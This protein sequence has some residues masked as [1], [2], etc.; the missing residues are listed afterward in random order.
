MNIINSLFSKRLCVCL[1]LSFGVFGAVNIMAQK[2]SLST[3]HENERRTPYPQIGQTLYINP[4]PLLVPKNRK[5]ADCLQF[6]LSQQK[7]FSGEGNMLSKPVPWCMFNPHQKLSAGKWYWRFRSVSSS[8]E[9]FPWSETMEFVMTDDVPTFVTPTFDVLLKKLSGETSR[10]NCFLDDKLGEARQKMYTH[11][12]YNRMITSGR[13]GLAANYSTDTLVSNHATAMVDLCEKLHTAYVLTQRDV[14][15]NKMVQLIRWMLPSR[16][17]DRQLSND[18]YAGDLAYLLACSYET[19]Y[20]R[21]TPQER[22]QMEQL[23]LR[24]IG[25]YYKSHFAGSMEN[26]IFNN[27]LW[28]FTLRRLTQAS[29]VLYDK[30]PEAHEFLEYAYELW[31]ARAPAT[32]F[33]RDGIWINGTCYFSANAITLYY[34]PAL[35]S[36]LTG[37]DFFQ[38]PWY[39]GVGKAMVYNWPPHSISVGWGDGHEQMNDKPLII[40]SAFAEFLHRELGDPYAAWFTGIDQRYLM[41]DEMRLYRMVRPEAKEKIATLPANEPK[42]TW[43]RDCGE[44]IANSNMA[45]YQNNLCLSFRSSPF[46]SGSHTQSTQN[47]FNLYFRGVPVYGSTGYYMNFTD[48]HNLLD[49]RHTRGHNTLLVDGI[50]QPFSIKAYG[51]IVRMLGG[52]N[53]SYCLGDA[54]NAYCGLNDY[55]MWIRNFANQGV[56]ESRENGFGETSLTLYRRH[57]FL[58]HPD[59]VV[60]YDEMEAKS[61]VRWDWLLHSPVPFAIDKDTKLLTTRNEAKQFTSVAQLFSNQACDITQTD[62]FVVAPDITKAV[63]GEKLANQWHLT[64]SFASSKRNRILTIIQV[65]PDGIKAADISRQGN[66]LQCGD[67]VIEAELNAK[68]PAKLFIENRVNKA[69][70]SYGTKKVSVGDHEYSLSAKEAS[71]LYDCV[72]GQWKVQEMTDIPVQP[73]GAISK[74]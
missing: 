11:P 19:C 33:N 69:T 42:A 36:H 67:W 23:M 56:E 41:D 12:E 40:R 10:L 45:D 3:V 39:K 68:N 44:M 64:A 2:Q 4:A 18:F 58:L 47:A 73:T 7:D 21:F 27:H 15:A 37:T 9:N 43:F 59:K 30:Y 32:G 57:I 46:G 55:P 48:P 62:Q 63:R 51:N 16:V 29:L 60:I 66:R 8:G 6:E 26:H 71:L 22:N 31:T 24:I 72:N 54:S 61:S 20:D 38:H 70:F 28:Q 5:Q 34:L 17:T 1:L 35:F 52:E 65:Q 50:G 53:I 49:Y 13:E 25:H 14:Y 74:Q